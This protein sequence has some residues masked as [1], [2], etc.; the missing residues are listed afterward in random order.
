MISGGKGDS[1]QQEVKEGPEWELKLWVSD[2]CMRM[3]DRS[4]TAH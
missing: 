3:P 4:C 2:S 1:C